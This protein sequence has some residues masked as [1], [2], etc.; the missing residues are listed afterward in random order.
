[1]R[2]RIGIIDI[3]EP[4]HAKGLAWTEI[5]CFVPHS[6]T[7]ERFQNLFHVAAHVVA[8]LPHAEF[9]AGERDLGSAIGHD[10]TLGEL[11]DVCKASSWSAQSRHGSRFLEPDV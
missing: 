4:N 8:P 11:G 3:H 1:M 10:L 5:P 6:L 9:V 2:R 7:V